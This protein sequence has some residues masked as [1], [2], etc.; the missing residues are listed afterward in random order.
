[1]LFRS[2]RILHADIHRVGVDVGLH[3]I[4]GEAVA[5]AA[6]GDVYKRQ[7]LKMPKFSSTCTRGAKFFWLSS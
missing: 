3:L 6:V 5:K 1:M 7:P 4:G 2:G